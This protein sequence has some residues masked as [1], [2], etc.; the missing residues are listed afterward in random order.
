ME[1]FLRLAK[2]ID[3]QNIE[4]VVVDAWKKESLL[5]VSHIELGGVRAFILVPRTG[6]WQ[7][8]QELSQ[9]IFS[10]EQNLKRQ[11][12]LE[13]EKASI[14]IVYQKKDAQRARQTLQILEEI[15]PG[16]VSLYQ[17]NIYQDWPKQSMLLDRA[18]LQKPWSLD[19]LLKKLTLEKT[20]LLPFEES[21]PDSD[22]VLILGSES[23]NMNTN[24]L[25]IQGSAEL[26]NK[27]GDALII[28][29]N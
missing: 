20:T 4:T 9:S 17:I 19:T 29:Q 5:R 26:D 1:S 7:E 11:A 13:E 3:T 16:S 24:G 18:D 27:E 14:G 8:T 6:T 23:T 25:S 28:P 10:R 21:A 12:L 22:L 15:F 2:K